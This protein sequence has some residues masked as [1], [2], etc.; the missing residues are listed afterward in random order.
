MSK[1]PDNYSSINRAWII[2]KIKKF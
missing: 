2:V 1:F